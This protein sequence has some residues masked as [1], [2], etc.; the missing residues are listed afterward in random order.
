M[1]VLGV[2][3]S[4][5]KRG[6]SWTLL[7]EALAGARESGAETE[8]VTIAELDIHPCDGCYAC[9]KTKV[10]HIRDDMHDVYPKVEASDG[11]IFATPVYFMGMTGPAKVS[12]D[13]LYPLYRHQ[14]LANKV[15]G[16]IAVA[17]RIGHS[18]VWNAF[19]LFFQLSRM[20]QSDFVA[21]FA[22]ER[23]DIKRDRHAM[24]AS[25]ELGRLVVAIAGNKV[26]IPEEYRVMLARMVSTKY[27]IDMAPA[28]DRFERP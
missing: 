1:K 6:N 10:C 16:S 3:C 12:V 9:I 4:P 8:M 15:G 26:E 19:N 21:G 22:S 18:Q 25:S 14:K 11:I 23:G 28:G 24:K 13:R 7:E 5:R 27:G 17:T 20:R 2:N